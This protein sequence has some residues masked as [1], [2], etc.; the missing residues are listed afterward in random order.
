MYAWYV[1][2]CGACG[3]GRISRIRSAAVFVLSVQQLFIPVGFI[4]AFHLLYYVCA[5]S[6]T[7][8][9]ST[10]LRSGYLSL[11]GGAHNRNKTFAVVISCQTPS[12]CNDFRTWVHRQYTYRST[13]N[14]KIT[15]LSEMHALYRRFKRNAWPT[16]SADNMRE[17]RC[18]Q[19]APGHELRE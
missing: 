8:W 9:S 17:Q 11:F 2:C 14:E 19:E 13:R 7:T 12:F 15:R 18:K 3:E 1:Y 5:V 6:L 16:G 4:I 10:R